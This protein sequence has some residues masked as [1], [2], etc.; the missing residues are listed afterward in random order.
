MGF[1]FWFKIVTIITSFARFCYWL[2]VKTSV[3]SVTD[4]HSLISDTHRLPVK[5]PPSSIRVV[6]KFGVPEVVGNEC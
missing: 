3:K 6:A 1:W 5:A 4:V 2:F